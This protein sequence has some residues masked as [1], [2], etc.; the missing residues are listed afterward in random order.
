MSDMG[1]RYDLTC[2]C[3]QDLH[4]SDRFCSA[5]GAAAPEPPGPASPD[6]APLDQRTETALLRVL[7]DV[8]D[9]HV[10]LWGR[11]GEI[12]VD[13]PVAAVLRRLDWPQVMLDRGWVGPDRVTAQRR[14]RITDTGRAALAAAG[15]RPGSSGPH[16]PHGP[17]SVG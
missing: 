5:C 9:G 13:R 12:V 11:P 15:G 1:N 3:G 6:W 14:L 2:A 8:D 16:G 4:P 17:T 7:A 10:G